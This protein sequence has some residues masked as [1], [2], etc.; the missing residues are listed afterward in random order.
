M[1]SFVLRSLRYPYTAAA[2][3]VASSSK[4]NCLMDIF[5]IVALLYGAHCFRSN[6]G[7]RMHSA[8]TIII[9]T[10]E[11]PKPWKFLPVLS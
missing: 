8:V 7:N 6:M 9:T 4:C 11:I 10:I 5:L 1:T 2:V 3:V